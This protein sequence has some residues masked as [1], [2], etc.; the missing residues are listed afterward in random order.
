MTKK[1]ILTSKES[2]TFGLIGIT[3]PVKDYRISWLLNQMLAFDLVRCAD[4]LLPENPG[5][6]PAAGLFEQSTDNEGSAGFSCYS[7]EIEEDRLT[8]FLV[9]NRNDFSYL[10][11]ELKKTD[12]FLI[13]QGP[14][15]ETDIKSLQ[16]KINDIP[17]VITTSVIDPSRLKS[18]NNLVF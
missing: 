3:T 7:F 15:A 4:V 9:C 6:A 10:I 11:P 17:D 13:I 8:F 2:E 18:K 12:Y 16:R 5:S 14:Y 1:H